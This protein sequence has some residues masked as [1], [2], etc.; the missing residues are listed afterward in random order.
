[1]VLD[2]KGI[3]GRSHAVKVALAHRVHKCSAF[4][5]KDYLWAEIKALIR[6]QP[7]H[8]AHILT[9]MLVNP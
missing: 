8:S 3:R 2:V 1:M 4:V 9:E 6:P 7:S 5:Q